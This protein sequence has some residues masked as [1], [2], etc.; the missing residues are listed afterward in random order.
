MKLASKSAC[1]LILA[2][3][4]F[5]GPA[6]AGKKEATPK[7]PPVETSSVKG[8]SANDKH[9]PAVIEMRK[10][11]GDPLLKNPASSPKNLKGH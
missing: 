5:A 8:E 6:V 9:R 10:A 11:G 4:F 7:P 3:A 1:A 2:A